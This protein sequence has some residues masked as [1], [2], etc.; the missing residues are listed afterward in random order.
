MPGH[1]G[2]LADEP[3]YYL[4]VLA[5]VETTE[6]RMVLAHRPGLRSITVGTVKGE[7]R[8]SWTHAAQAGSRAYRMAVL[9]DQLPLS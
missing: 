8:G 5:V 3:V 9:S 6:K 4:L 7:E 1:Q 2:A